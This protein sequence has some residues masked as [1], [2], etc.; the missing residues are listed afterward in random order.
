M[1]QEH[2]FGVAFRRGL[3]H[4]WHDMLVM[5]STRGPYVHAELFLQRGKTSRFYTSYDSSKGTC[6]INP[7]TR[8][9]PL[10]PHWEALRFPI[11]QRGYKAAYALILQL[12]TLPIPY[13][14][15]DL[16]QCAIP[17]MLPFERDLDCMNPASW[18]GTGVFCSQLCLLVLRRLVA[19]GV[20][21]AEP[22][23]RQALA[24]CNSRGC[25]PNALH[26]LL[27]TP[28]EKKATKHGV[29][30]SRARARQDPCPTSPWP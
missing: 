5:E 8:R 2:Y 9:L 17:V 14:N 30:P 28:T 12:M 15:R 6:A 18:T 27:L 29:R 1:S 13:N 22:P 26:Q 7:T 24:S 23:L 4:D 25:S 3:S 21:H 19:Q 16:W 20:L 11:N 10:P